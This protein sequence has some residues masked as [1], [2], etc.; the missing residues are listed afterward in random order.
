MI[1]RIAALLSYIIIFM[2]NSS[3]SQ[4]FEEAR[5]VGTKQDFKDF[6]CN[7]MIYPEEAL[8]NHIQGTVKVSFVVDKSGKTKDINVKNSAD[9][10]LADEAKRLVRLMLWEPATQ[11]GL[12]VS[13][14]H[15]VKIAFRHK[16]YKRDC[17]HRGYQKPAFA[18]ENQDTSF[19]VY[20]YGQVYPTPVPFFKDENM[21]LSKF[22]QKNLSYPELAMQQS[23]K[24]N[25]RIEFVVETSGKASHF[26]I[27]EGIGG[28]CNE[29]AKKII[30]LM[31]WEPGKLDSIP[32]RTRMSMEIRFNL[33]ESSDINYFHNDQNRSF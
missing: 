18:G 22:I 7:E 29:E 16:K 23:I 3:T 32:V 20:S 26:R 31:R 5:Y 30:K 28:G 15:E 8:N 24:G 1:I 6:L 9:P 2:L 14:R 33:N 25:V 19:R 13:S 11:Y 10:L 4:N 17:D 21:N 27:I 12:P